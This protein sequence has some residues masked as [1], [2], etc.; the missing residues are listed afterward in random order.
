[1]SNLTL[2]NIKTWR[3][4][5]NMALM[6]CSKSDNPKFDKHPAQYWTGKYK[7]NGKKEYKWKVNPT[8]DELPK[9]S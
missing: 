3:D 4:K 7:T 2:E 9:R 8:E 6:V 1:M 5:Y